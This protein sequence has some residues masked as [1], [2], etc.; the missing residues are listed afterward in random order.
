MNPKQYYVIMM[1][2]ATLAGYLQDGGLIDI[3]QHG[4]TV[5]RSHYE[6]V[7]AFE[8]EGQSRYDLVVVGTERK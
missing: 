3:G 8:R 7:T 6:M 2:G 1:E 4:V 5:Y